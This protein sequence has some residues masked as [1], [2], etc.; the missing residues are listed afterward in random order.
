MNTIAPEIDQR[1]RMHDSITS[2]LIEQY[3]RNGYAILRNALGPERVAQVNGEALRLVASDLGANSANL[4]SI[5]QLSE[6][7]LMR[8]YL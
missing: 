3:E 8:K 6:S 2:E 4:E 1:L 7:E 5:G